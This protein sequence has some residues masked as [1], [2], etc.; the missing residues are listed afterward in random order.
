MAGQY[1]LNFYKKIKLAQRG[2]LPLNENPDSPSAKDPYRKERRPGDGQGWDLTRPGNEEITPGGMGGGL[3]TNTRD[4][5][6][7]DG[8][9]RDGSSSGK[10]EYSDQLKSDMPYSPHNLV[11]DGVKVDPYETDI[12]FTDTDSPFLADKLNGGS[13]D[14]RGQPRIQNM[15]AYPDVV[16][17]VRD[18]LR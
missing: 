11:E 1:K 18:R 5:F 2:N 8:Y 3:G 15:Q 4:N 13:E 17:T 7:G 10:D 16:K 9:N 12:M 6:T 14:G